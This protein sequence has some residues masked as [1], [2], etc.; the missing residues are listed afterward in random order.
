MKGLIWIIILFATAVGCALLIQHFPGN[1]Y[2]QVGEYMLRMNVRLFVIGLIITM[3]I[4]HF[5]LK[6]VFGV[7]ATP[8]K[9]SRFGSSR[10]SRK[11]LAALNDAGVAFFEG[12]YQKAASEAAKVLANQHAGDNRVLALMIA[13][14]ASHRVGEVGK[15]DGYLKDMETLLPAK[16]QLP[17]YLLQAESALSRKDYLGA[18]EA[19][20]AAAQI[21]KNLPELLAL[22]LR[23]AVA[24]DH[25]LEILETVDKLQKGSYLTKEEVMAYRSSAYRG[26]VENASQ[27]SSLKTALHRI[28]NDVKSGALCVAI[29]EQYATLGLHQDA[30]AWVRNYYPQTHH[31]EL[32][33]VLINSVRYLNDSEQRK[34]IDVADGWLKAKPDDIE[35]LSCL[36]DLCITKQLWSKAQGYLEAS[37][38]IKPTAHAR[39]A[40]AKV[41]DETHATVQADEQRR[42]LLSEM[43]N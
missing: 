20:L 5:M 30:V 29:A 33:N 32:L 36:G 22:Q 11:A 25:P 41:F 28:P 14:Q 34:A 16:A 4:L 37:I 10:K 17:R 15:R 35:L 6:F 38:A 39:L 23:V 21:D 40:L 3:I 12:R 8:G 9:M 18:D 26:L 27:V 42:L 43:A 7:L 19:L 24:K 1:V 2:V 31:A 13:A